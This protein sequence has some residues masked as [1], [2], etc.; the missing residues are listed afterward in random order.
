MEFKSFLKGHLNCN[1]ASAISQ[2]FF[3]ESTQIS[4][5]GK[6]NKNYDEFVILRACCSLLSHLNQTKI[7]HFCVIFVS[8]QEL[9]SKMHS[10]K[11]VCENLLST[12]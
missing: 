6:H 1:S 8:L 12:Y 10:K 7:S 4:E 5:D 3:Q 2:F 9:L 11:S